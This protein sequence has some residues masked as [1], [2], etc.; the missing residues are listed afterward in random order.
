MI[1]KPCS[2]SQRAAKNQF[3]KVLTASVL[4]ATAK[5]TAAASSWW[6]GLSRDAFRVRAQEELERMQGSQFGKQQALVLG[7]RSGKRKTQNQDDP[8]ELDA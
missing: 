3:K 8:A 2:P 1:R 7:P 5:P 6:I 4:A